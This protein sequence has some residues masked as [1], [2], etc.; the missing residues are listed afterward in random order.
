VYE[1]EINVVE[2]LDTILAVSQRTWR[3]RSDRVGT[4]ELTERVLEPPAGVV[5]GQLG[6]DE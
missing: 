6:R 5:S 3:S 1:V 4:N 2:T